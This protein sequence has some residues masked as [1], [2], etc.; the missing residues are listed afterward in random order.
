[1][2]K[3]KAMKKTKATDPRASFFDSIYPH[4]VYFSDDEILPFKA[5]VLQVGNH[6]TEN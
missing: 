2:A 6:R 1:M 5:R 4:L 3:K